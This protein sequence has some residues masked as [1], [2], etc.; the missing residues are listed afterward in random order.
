MIFC[1]SESLRNLFFLF[2]IKFKNHKIKHRQIGYC[3][4]M[5]ISNN[6]TKKNKNKKTCKAKCYHTTTIELKDS[7]LCLKSQDIT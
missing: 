6:L 3:T 1:N 7:M 5:Q 2:Y 4:S